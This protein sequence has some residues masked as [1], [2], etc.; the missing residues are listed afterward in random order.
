MNRN[1][2]TVLFDFDYTLADSS[3][4]V[5]EC[6][7]FALD[8]LGLPTASYEKVCR[9]IGLSLGDALAQ[10]AGE[11]HRRLSDEFLKLFLE[12]ADQV[13]VEKTVLFDGVPE[14]MARLKEPGRVIG[15]VSTKYRYRIESI[16]GRYNCQDVF[17]VIIGGED[18]KEH[19]PHPGG[20]LA[21]L[22]E[23]DTTGFDCL[24]VGDSVVDAETAERA[25]VDFAAAL[26]GVTAETDFSGYPALGI[27]NHVSELPGLLHCLRLANGLHNIDNRRNHGHTGLKAERIKRSFR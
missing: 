23:L 18:V 7:N 13:M 4:P 9:T 8:G 6:I 11:E 12:M 26:T 17:D 22:S 16:L 5:S 19:K 25:G 2:Q 27:I 24:Y 14:T 10:L 3:R 21:A 15:I 20:L 1:F